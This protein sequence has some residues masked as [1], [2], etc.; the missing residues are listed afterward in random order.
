M[1]VKVKKSTM[2]KA[3]DINRGLVCSANEV[4]SCI[5]INILDRLAGGV[6]VVNK[7]GVLR[8]SGVHR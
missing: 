4:Q 1:L 3:H 2:R 5:F 8:S 6:L 7:D